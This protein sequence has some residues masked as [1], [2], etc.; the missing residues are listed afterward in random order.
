MRARTIYSTSDFVE[1]SCNVLMEALTLIVYGT[2]LRYSF[3]N[4]VEL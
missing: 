1:A 4:I 3:G 2:N